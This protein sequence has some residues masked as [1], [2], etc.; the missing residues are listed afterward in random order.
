MF[1]IIVTHPRDKSRQVEVLLDAPDGF[2]DKIYQELAREYLYRTNYDA[3]CLV[4]EYP[5]PK[6]K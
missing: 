4:T 6:G 2:T 5:R 3:Y 1:D